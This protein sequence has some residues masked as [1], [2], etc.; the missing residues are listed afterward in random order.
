MRIGVVG[1]GM[2]VA[3][4][5]RSLIDLK[6]RI[7]V[8]YAFSPSAAR[9][10]K[11]TETYG[12]ATSDSIEPIFT[13][14]S[15]EAVMILTPPN[16]HLELVERAAAAG[17]HILLEKPLDITITRSE[18]IVEAARKANVSLGVVFQNRFSPGALA[19][20]D[21]VETGRLG[22]LVSASATISNWRAQSYYDEPERGT[23]ARDGGGVLLTQAIHI[24]DLLV[25]A[26]GLPVDVAAFATTTP[27]HRMETEDLAA[28]ALRFGNG[29]IG[30]I[31]ASTVAYPGSDGQVSLIG[32]KGAATLTGTTLRAAFHDGTTLDVSP[33]IAGTGAGAD[34]MAFGH[35]L[36]RA[37]IAGFADAIPGTPSPSGEDALKVHYLIDAMLTSS[38]RGGTPV[39][40]KGSRG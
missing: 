15:V 28:A 30:T 7:E 19:L 20:R 11:F 18:A 35:D 17:K 29:A 32:T 5:A 27:I 34:P 22:Q 23:K 40:P 9:R 12:I 38:E 3:P 14:P 31:L 10:A 25:M 24:L 16:T 2:A 21:I 26:A 1:L 13:D 8:A 4:H 6:D 36:H 33:A 39:S 37:L